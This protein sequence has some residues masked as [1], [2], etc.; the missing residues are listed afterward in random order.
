M[1]PFKTWESLSE[2]RR[3][4]A[5]GSIF[6][7]AMTTMAFMGEDFVQQYGEVYFFPFLAL[8]ALPGLLISQK[9]MLWVLTSDLPSE[10]IKIHYLFGFISCLVNYPLWG[11]YF[12]FIFKHT[13]SRFSFGMGTLIFFLIAFFSGMVSVSYCMRRGIAILNTSPSFYLLFVGFFLC[14]LS[15]GVLISWILESDSTPKISSV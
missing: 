14:L 12:A 6:G 7:L 4:W 5:I 11:A 10:F 8:P 13:P 3:G 2:A 15:L 1:G 9:I